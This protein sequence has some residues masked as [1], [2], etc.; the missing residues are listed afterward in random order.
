MIHCK[1]HH[2]EDQLISGNVTAMLNIEITSHSNTADNLT[3]EAETADNFLQDAQTYMTYKILI[4]LDRY[5]YPI[6]IPLEYLGNTLSFLV[7]IRPNNRTISTCIYMAA[8]SVND[9]VLIADALHYWLVSAVHIHQWY[10]SE[11]KIN[12]YFA[13]V[14]LQMSSYQVLAMTI[15]KYEA[16]K[17]PHKTAAYITPRR[18]N[19]VIFTLFTLGLFHNVPH[20]FI[21]T[22]IG[23]KCYGYSVKGTFTKVYS[24]FTIVLN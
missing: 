2:E 8:I 20:F 23:G 22:L 16:I 5:W 14:S 3:T 15:D 11:C 1:N 10:L 9:N 21:T 7:M 19:V 13:Y 24:W 12:A 17:W 6:L 18:T 4:Y